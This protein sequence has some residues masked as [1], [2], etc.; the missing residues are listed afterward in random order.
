LSLLSPG[1]SSLKP[2]SQGEWQTGLGLTEQV[3]KPPLDALL[4]RTF[5]W[6]SPSP[7]QGSFFSPTLRTQDFGHSRDKA[8]SGPWPRMINILRH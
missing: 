4:I 2:S 5:F 1:A 7:T 6:G 3:T 8:E